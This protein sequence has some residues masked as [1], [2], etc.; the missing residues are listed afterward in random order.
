ML[1]REERQD[2]NGHGEGQQASAFHN[3]RVIVYVS[4]EGELA[5]SHLSRAKA[6]R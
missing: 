6:A 1:V 2:G 3:S 5:V 4:R